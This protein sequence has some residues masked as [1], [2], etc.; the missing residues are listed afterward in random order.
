M[1]EMQELQQLQQQIAELQQKAKE[2]AQ[3]NKAQIVADMKQQITLYGITATELGF[4]S[5]DSE[6]SSKTGKDGQK[7]TTVSV[8]YRDGDNT[9]TGRGKQ[10]KWLVEAIA[11]GKSKE[12]FLINND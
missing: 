3:K 5:S 10:P 2:L 4:T 1:N 12:D 9:W 7:S 6:K 11:N 8:K